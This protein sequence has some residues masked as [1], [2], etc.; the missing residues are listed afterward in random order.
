MALDV[1][2]SEAGD[3]IFK[4]FNYCSKQKSVE[5]YDPLVRN[6]FTNEGERPLINPSIP[7]LEYILREA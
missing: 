2:A 6:A 4:D 7:S 3:I 5:K 1:N